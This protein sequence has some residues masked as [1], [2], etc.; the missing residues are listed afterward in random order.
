MNPADLEALLKAVASGKTSPETA[1]GALATLG[2]EDLGFSKPDHHRELRT[3]FPEVVFGAGKTA[4]Q[5]AAIVERIASRGQNVLVTRTTAEVHAVVAAR[6]PA[7]VHH[8][9][10]RCFTVITAPAVALPGKVAVVC[11]GTS[12]VAVA[13]EAAVT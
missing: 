9:T 10:A 8:P 2:Y 5:V 7:A 11:A 13:E 3:G 12:D 1:M 6:W 4:E